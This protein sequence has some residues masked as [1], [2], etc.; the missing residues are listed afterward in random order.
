[1][2]IDATIYPIDHSPDVTHFGCGLMLSKNLN[3]IEKLD[4]FNLG[5]VAG[6]LDN[7]LAQ[8]KY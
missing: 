8:L 2:V 3:V 5:M 4:L 6:L 7:K 1:M